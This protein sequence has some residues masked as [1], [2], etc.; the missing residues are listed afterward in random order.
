MM[1]SRNNSILFLENH[2]PDKN[3]DGMLV[4][5]DD[6]EPES[7]VFGPDLQRITDYT[8]PSTPTPNEDEIAAKL[9]SL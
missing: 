8:A 2:E 3:S 9:M 4:D 7:P 5:G 6:V 1:P